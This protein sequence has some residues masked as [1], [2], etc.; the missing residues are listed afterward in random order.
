M[1]LNRIQRTVLARSNR[2]P[3]WS[4]IG[5]APALSKHRTTRISSVGSGFLGL[6]PDLTTFPFPI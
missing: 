2:R 5:A 6:A 4:G 1:A 3:T